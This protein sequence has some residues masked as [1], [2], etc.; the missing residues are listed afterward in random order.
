MPWEPRDLLNPGSQVH[1]RGPWLEETQHKLG[2]W[3]Q[4][5]LGAFTGGEIYARLA[6]VQISARCLVFGVFLLGAWRLSA[7]CSESIDHEAA[8]TGI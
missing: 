1:P 4:A 3:G 6:L 7:R 8:L 2:R 5:S